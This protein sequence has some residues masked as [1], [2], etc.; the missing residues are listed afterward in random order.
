MTEKEKVNGTHAICDMQ[1]LVILY[2]YNI[3]THDFVYNNDIICQAK[4]TKLKLKHAKELAKNQVKEEEE[5][6][7]EEGIHCEYIIMSPQYSTF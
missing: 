2:Y 4:I 7:E 6:E 3:V 5:E 1:F